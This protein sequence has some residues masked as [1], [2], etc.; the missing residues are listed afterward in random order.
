[1]DDEEQQELDAANT[2]TVQSG[3]NNVAGQRGSFLSKL[4]K[5]TKR[6]A[7]FERRERTVYKTN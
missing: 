5:L 4:T 1:M 3:A 6:L 2:M 7:F